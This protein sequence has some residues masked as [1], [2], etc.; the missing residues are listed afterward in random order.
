MNIKELKK[1]L[2]LKDKD[3]AEF[4][5]MKQRS[6]YESSARKRLEESFVRIYTFLK[7]GEKKNKE[8]TTTEQNTGT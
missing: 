3:L 2:G 4:F 6:Y 5:G 8:I 7:D 1:E